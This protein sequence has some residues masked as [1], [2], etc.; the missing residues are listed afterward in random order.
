LSSVS[1]SNRNNFKE[2]S[3]FE[4]IEEEFSYYKQWKGWKE[5][6]EEPINTAYHRK[7]EEDT[8]IEEKVVWKDNNQISS[9]NSQITNISDNAETEDTEM[10]E[11]ENSPQVQEHHQQKESDSKKQEVQQ[12]PP[13]KWSWQ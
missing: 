9:T 5:P 4:G 1:E 12:L 13:Y 2:P 11:V 10:T 6:F 8:F 7:R 3:G